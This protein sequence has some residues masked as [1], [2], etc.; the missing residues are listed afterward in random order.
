MSE[1]S[2][3]ILEL[4]IPFRFKYG[5]AKARHQGVQSILCI[6]RDQ[7]GREGLGEAIPRSYV[8]GE[9]TESIRKDLPDIIDQLRGRP[10]N[11]MKTVFHQIEAAR[12]HAVPNGAFCALELALTDLRAQQEN[13]ALL[14]SDTVTSALTYT[15]SIG[16]ANGANLTAQLLLY[17][18]MGLRHFKVKVGNAHDQD[19][20][21]GI[22]KILGQ[23]VTLF[24]DANGAWE[25]EAAVRHIEGLVKEDVWAVEEPL[26]VAVPSEN[27]SLSGQLCRGEELTD[28]HLADNAWVQAR[29]P[30]PLIADESLISLPGAQRIVESQAFKIFNI[31]LSKCGGYARSAQFAALAK[32]SG[33]S[34]SLGA[35]VGESP[36]LATAGTAFGA[37]Q[38]EH[39]YIQGHSHRVLH[40]ARFVGGG[41][42]LRRGGKCTPTS[43]TGAGLRLN[44]AALTSLVTERTQTSL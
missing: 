36:V 16:M 1:T 27:R 33:L 30:V 7:D 26:R 3:E 42:R 38:R 17:K 29:V 22:R 41:P 6:A 9:S 35:M 4:M 31:R 25:K 19:R 32:A 43:G 5:H 11:E 39:L 12:P 8:T 18:A 10:L 13:Q 15:A 34:F 37:K 24:A 2:I 14:D 40:G 28:E 20:V 44:R 23:D 21:R